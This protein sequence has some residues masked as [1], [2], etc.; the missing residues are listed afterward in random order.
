MVSTR[1]WPTEE[2]CEIDKLT[3]ISKG[4]DWLALVPLSSILL[5][6]QGLRKIMNT[7]NLGYNKA[8][9]VRATVLCGIVV[10]HVVLLLAVTTASHSS[11]YRVLL[12]CETAVVESC[13]VLQYLFKWL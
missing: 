11:V 13:A 9:F 6:G 7:G 3:Y 1:E 4:W 12:N 5:F 8:T 10:V 2:R